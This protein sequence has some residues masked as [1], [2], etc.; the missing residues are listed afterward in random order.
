MTG[1]T[2]QAGALRATVF[3]AA[4]LTLGGC[5]S[6]ED[7]GRDDAVVGVPGSLETTEGRLEGNLA[8]YAPEGSLEATVNVWDDTISARLD[9][10]EFGSWVMLQVD[11]SGIDVRSVEDGATLTFSNG[12]L[13]SS[14]GVD[15]PEGVWLSSLGCAGPFVGNFDYDA[16][17]LDTTVEFGTNTEGQR[18]LEIRAGFSGAGSLDG[19][20]VLPD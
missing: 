9:A 13:V 6:W 4:A 2:T 5:L 10:L 18:E 12:R 19:S 16:P 17:A 3:I 11:V 20:V 8:G 1:T 15:A 7:P 14:T